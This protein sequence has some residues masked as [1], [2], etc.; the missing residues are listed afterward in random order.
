[1]ENDT[2]L[3]HITYT[4]ES[5]MARME[6]TNTRC[7]LV[8]VLLIILLFVT[9]GAWIYYESQYAVVTEST[10]VTQSNDDGVNNFIG[11]DGDIVNGET[12]Y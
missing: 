6:R 2:L 4:H 10:T 1:M 8:I 9:N 5:A 11:E 7:F 3:H 12:D